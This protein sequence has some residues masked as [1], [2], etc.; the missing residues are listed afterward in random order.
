MVSPKANNLSQV[1]RAKCT[2]SCPSAHSHRGRLPDSPPRPLGGF[3]R[4]FLNAG[5]GGPQ[6]WNFLN[7]KLVNFQRSQGPTGTVDCGK[8]DS[9]LAGLA[10]HSFRVESRKFSFLETG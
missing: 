10:F 2:L 7:C 5:S 3:H 4:A 1:R 9:T 8:D 6:P